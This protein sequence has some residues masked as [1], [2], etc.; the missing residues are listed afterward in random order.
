MGQKIN[1]NI[2]RLSYKNNEWDSK[3]LENNFE[4][5]SLYV[6]QDFEIKNYINQFFK[7]Y[8]LLINSC[9]IQRSEET[10]NIYISYYITLKSL[11]VI[12]NINLTQKII[13][14]KKIKSSNKEKNINKKR[15]WI[16]YLLK[17]KLYEKNFY[18]K[19]NI[20]AEK[21]LESLSLFTNKT[22]NINIVLQNLNNKLSLKFKDFQYQ[23]FNKTIIKLRKYSKTLFFRECINILSIVIKKKNHL[24]Y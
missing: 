4:E 18:F 22:L 2:F 17:K 7:Q 10:L 6:Y 12:N 20:F 23:S 11:N 14:K 21:L 19:T 1:A 5:L 8:K 24:N 3:Y 13:V 16:I 15:L 9:E